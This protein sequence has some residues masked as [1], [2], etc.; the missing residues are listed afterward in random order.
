MGANE[1][2]IFPGQF[3]ICNYFPCSFARGNVFELIKRK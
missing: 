2:L 1:K 3:P